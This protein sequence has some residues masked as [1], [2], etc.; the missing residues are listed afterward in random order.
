MGLSTGAS[1]DML[2]LAAGLEEFSNLARQI[3]AVTN[4]QIFF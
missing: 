1:G 3:I 4:G 2:N